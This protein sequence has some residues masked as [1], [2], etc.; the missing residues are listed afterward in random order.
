MISQR[1]RQTSLPRPPDRCRVCCGG[2]P[3]ASS[4]ANG[5]LLCPRL[6]SGHRILASGVSVS[7]SVGTGLIVCFAYARPCRVCTSVVMTRSASSGRADYRLWRAARA[8]HDRGT[9]KLTTVGRRAGLATHTT[10]ESGGSATTNQPAAHQLRFGNGSHAGSR[11]ITLCCFRCS[12][13][14]VRQAVP[15]GSQLMGAPCGSEAA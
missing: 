5:C 15:A 13:A 8:G 6:P 3:R 14:S 1:S 4:P 11:W 10:N 9:S 7:N 12:A 2:W